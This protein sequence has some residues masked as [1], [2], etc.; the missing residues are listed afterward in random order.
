MFMLADQVSLPATAITQLEAVVALLQ[1][2]LESA[3]AGV[4]LHGS[5]ATSGFDPARSDLDILAI[6]TETLTPDDQQALGVGLLAISGDPHPLEFSIVIEYDLAHWSHPCAY[7]FHFSESH[8]S[9]FAVGRFSPQAAH[10]E[11]LAAHFTVAK[12][13]GIDLLGAYPRA[14]LPEIPRHDYLAAL[15]GDFEWAARHTD[16]LHDYMLANACRTQAYLQ[17]GQVLSKRE[18]L[19][20]CRA[21][22][23]DMAAVVA[24]VIAALRR[25][26][27]GKGHS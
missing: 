1:R 9:A 7:A 10:D 23:I 2:Q 21:Q 6:V 11:D 27:A 19:D 13:R 20:W 26:I 3:L 18:G 24:D 17:T 25:E 14:R 4:I 15:L 12:A 22:D 8:R 5:A 16:D